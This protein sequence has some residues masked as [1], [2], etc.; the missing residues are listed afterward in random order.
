MQAIEIKF[1]AP[2]ATKG[3]RYKVF[4]HSHI[5]L[6]PQEHLDWGLMN[7]NIPISEEYRVKLALEYFTNAIGWKGRW[8]LGHLKNGNWVFVNT[9]DQFTLEDIETKE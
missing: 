4:S 6:Y 7:R 5:K 3:I 9:N 1:I 8:V 2:T